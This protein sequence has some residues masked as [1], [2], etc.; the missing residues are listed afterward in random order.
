MIRCVFR[1]IEFAQGYDGVLRTTEGYFYLLDS[2][3]IALAIGVWVF[4]WPPAILRDSSALGGARSS[5]G[6]TE[7]GQALKMNGFH[8]GA[9]NS[10][11][12][13]PSA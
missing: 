3:P 7:S 6:S 12:R 2:L 8:N 9:S 10:H 13:L 5:V 1:V 4:V 11:Y